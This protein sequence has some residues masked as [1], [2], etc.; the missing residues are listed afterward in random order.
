MDASVAYLQDSDK[1]ERLNTL[2]KTL[3]DVEN[4]REC[5]KWVLKVLT[6]ALKQ[7]VEPAKI[8][9]FVS[10]NH[11]LSNETKLNIVKQS[12]SFYSL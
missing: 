9:K 1:I 10:N 11:G 5:A 2:N 6:A 8:E 12:V 7:K 3:V 4:S